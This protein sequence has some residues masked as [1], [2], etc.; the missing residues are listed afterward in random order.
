M[1]FPHYITI[2]RPSGVLPGG[3][4]T[5]DADEGTWSD[6]TSTP[7]SQ[8]VTKGRADVQDMGE[9]IERDTAGMPTL[10]D[11]FRA[12][13][14]TEKKARFCSPGD[15]VNVEWNN[16]MPDLQFRIKQVQRLDGSLVL[17]RI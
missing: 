13:F 8:T 5:Q 12:Y 7:D 1:E 10:I 2:T 4:G 3:S 11:G 17:Q 9:L 6:N 15:I 14:R 16:G